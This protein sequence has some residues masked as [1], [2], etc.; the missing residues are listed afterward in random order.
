MTAFPWGA[1]PAPALRCDECRRR[2]GKVNTH[3]VTADGATLLCINCHMAPG[4][5]QTRLHSRLYPSCP[6]IWHDLGD[7]AVQFASRAGA[8]FVLAHPEQKACA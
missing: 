6:D 7:H 2:I 5:T 4:P 8:W 1:G 3:T